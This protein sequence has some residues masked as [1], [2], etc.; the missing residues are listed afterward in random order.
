[1]SSALTLPS[2]G[3]SVERYEAGPAAE[4]PEPDPLPARSRVAFAAAHVVADPRAPGDPVM[5]PRVDW[6]ATMAYRRHL[7]SHGL[8]VA[9]AMD[10]AQR[11]GGLDWPAARELI[12]RTA[13]EARAVGGRLA[14]GA[15]TDQLDPRSPASIGRIRDAYREQCELVEAEGATAVLMASRHLAAAADGPGDYRSVYDAVIAAAQRPVILHWLGEVFDPELAGYWGAADPARATELVS[16][17]IANH[18]ER[19]DGIKVSL[20]DAALEREL[21]ARLPA[22]VRLY[23][24]DDFNYPELIRGDAAGASDALLG[25]FDAIAPQAAAALRAL[26]AGDHARYDELLEPTLPLA[27][28]V[29]AQ[30]T[31]HYKTGLV[32]LAYLNGHQTH[33]RM[34]G[35]QEGA[36]SIVHLAELFRLADR[37][38]V[39][40]DPEVAAARFRP[41]LRLAAVDQD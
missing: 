20:L 8:G 6:D 32:F 33:F 37:A 19:V 21:R 13:A 35:A 23:T 26:D 36:R 24:G 4:L 14:C 31:A 5:E 11:G 38:G 40:S 17:L 18:A 29:F 22:G 34:V 9:D 1:V 2:A 3:G 7:W 10:T 39:L 25:I 16:E 27:R 15:G 30:P 12:Q 41:L 28:H